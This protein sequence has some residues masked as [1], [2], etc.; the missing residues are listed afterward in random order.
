M[1]EKREKDLLTEV[2]LEV[3]EI[4]VNQQHLSEDLKKV[5]ERT[6]K[7]DH[8]I[9]GNGEAGINER[10]RNIEK[11]RGFRGVVNNWQ[12]TG[13]NVISSGSISAIIVAIS[14]ATSGM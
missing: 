1:A 2:L 7:I 5:E 14:Q 6:E 11:L 4:S 12:A 8:S 10:L 13:V 3:R 9:R